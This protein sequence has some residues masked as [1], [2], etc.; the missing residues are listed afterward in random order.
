MNKGKQLFGNDLMEWKFVCSSCGN[1]QSPKDFKDY[2]HKGATP[3]SAYWNCIGRYKGTRNEIFSKKQPCN[4]S[5]GGL[6]NVNKT[7]VKYPTE[8]RELRVFNFMK[9][10]GKVYLSA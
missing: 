4:Y 6:F 3:S 7:V 5:S 9:K 8:F 1:I 2:Q 10:I